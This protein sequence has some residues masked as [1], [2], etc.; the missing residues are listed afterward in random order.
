MSQSDPIKD[1]TILQVRREDCYAQLTNTRDLLKSYAKSK[2]TLA[3]AKYDYAISLRTEFKA[4][5][6]EILIVNTLVDVKDQLERDK[7][8]S[9]FDSLFESIE[10]LYSEVLDYNAS[11]NQ[12][13]ANVVLPQVQVQSGVRLPNIKV[14]VFTN[15]VKEFPAF[16]KLFRCVY[17]NNPSLSDTERFYY[18]LSLLT[19][20]S[21]ALVQKYPIS[22]QG[23]KD[24]YKAL[25][26]RYESSRTLATIYVNELFNFEPLKKAT[27][28][29]L[30]KYLEIHHNQ[31]TALKSLSDVTDLG[32]FL[33][34]QLCARNLDPL[35]RRLFEQ[36][37]STKI[38][39]YDSLIQFVTKQC[40]TQSLLDNEKSEQVKS[41]ASNVS[42]PTKRTSNPVQLHTSN[43]P[44]PSVKEGHPNSSKNNSPSVSFKKNVSC[45]FC[46]S[47][48]SDHKIYQC[49]AYLKLSH[50][51]RV[52]W[53]QANSRCYG[54]LGSFMICQTVEV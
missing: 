3:Q 44:R 35:T 6:S 20:E 22:D 46:K 19:G 31:V 54:C 11:K 38:P 8:Q 30:C 47:D 42:N 43:R 51:D 7:T 4:I 13:Q 26:D 25:K 33:L 5:Q 34:M 28:T 23:F 45:G 12:N 53:I 15:N 39:T 9:S 2:V 32:D 17:M 29:A 50:A 36:Q 1:L 37:N 27:H 18:L 10:V 24:A 14:P 48:S 16:D 49:E 21:L 52:K 40:Q 41:S